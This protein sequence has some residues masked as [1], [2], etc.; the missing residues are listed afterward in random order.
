MF[1][2]NFDIKKHFLENG[3]EILTIKKDT[4]ISSINLGIKVGAMYESLEEKG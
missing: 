4:Q 2:L 3:L 1:K